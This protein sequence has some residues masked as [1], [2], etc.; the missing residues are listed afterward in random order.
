MRRNI[1][2]IALAL[3]SSWAWGD[4]KLTPQNR[5]LLEMSRKLTRTKLD[6]ERIIVELERKNKEIA[7]DKAE[8][9]KVLNSITVPEYKL[10]TNTVSSVI[11][12]DG[13][14]VFDNKSQKVSTVRKV[15]FK[16][17]A[18]VRRLAK[19]LEDPRVRKIYEKYCDN[20]CAEI[21]EEFKAEWKMVN[22]NYNDTKT[23]IESNSKVYTAE[24]RKIDANAKREYEA[25]VKEIDEKMGVLKRRRSQCIVNKKPLT[26]DPPE[27]AEIDRELN[28]LESEKKTVRRIYENNKYTKSYATAQDRKTDANDAVLAAAD[29]R[30]QLQS[31]F[32]VYNAKIKD[33]VFQIMT[34]KMAENQRLIESKKDELA[35]VELLLRNPDIVSSEIADA[36]MD[37]EAD[38]LVSE[39]L[40]LDRDEVMAAAEARR[41][42]A[43]QAA[44]DEEERQ[45]QQ[46]L[47]RKR[48]AA[49]LVEEAENAKLERER[50]A[51]KLAEDAEQ[52]KLERERERHRMAE[53]AATRDV[54]AQAALEEA[55]ARLQR[56]Q[57]ADQREQKLFEEELEYRKSK[58]RR[59]DA[60]SDYINSR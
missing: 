35:K 57:Q 47:A 4:V 24:V 1:L 37:R 11:A 44:R 41:A 52:A 5:N 48:D 30:N 55:R 22:E 40:G 25:S 21:L 12:P 34:R 6:C 56:Q 42:A 15:K 32:M 8:F 45:Y 36:Y 20:S 39:L 7:K 16:Q 18:R 19:I 53:E 54:R 50:E 43:A 59:L 28:R 29:L 13:S 33:D 26:P 38:N 14:M 49:R 9:R 2:A 3:V 17:D 23:M 51:A 58:R 10:V 60:E 46:E 27:V 31:L